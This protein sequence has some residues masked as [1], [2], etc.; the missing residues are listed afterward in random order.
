MVFERSGGDVMKASGVCL[1][2]LGIALCLVGGI[3]ALM[4]LDAYSSYTELKRAGN[5][6][7]NLIGNDYVY[8]GGSAAVGLLAGIGFLILGSQQRGEGVKGSAS[9]GKRVPGFVFDG[10]HWITEDE[11]AARSQ[12]SVAP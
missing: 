5:P 12:K 1:V 4:T 11:W 7:A 3:L 8:R 9:V 10:E 2:I 6:F